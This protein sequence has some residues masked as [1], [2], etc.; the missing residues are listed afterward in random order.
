MSLLGGRVLRTED[1]RL[2][3]L[4]GRY[5]DDLELDGALHA[6]FVRSTVAHAGLRSIDTRDAVAAPGVAGVFTSAGMGLARLPP[7]LP[8]LDQEMRRSLLADDRLRYVG[9]PYAVV[10][11]ETKSAAID[12]AE[13]VHADVEVLPAVVTVD[14]SRNR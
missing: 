9:E 3:T 11:A 12:A 1:P 2:L 7:S 14:D 8:A 5:V 13:R 10:V 4:G 6:V